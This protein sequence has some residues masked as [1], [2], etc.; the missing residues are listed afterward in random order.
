MVARE[1]RVA[2]GGA[3]PCPDARRASCSERSAPL[4]S[5]GGSAV[6]T[7][8]TLPPRAGSSGSVRRRG[9]FSLCALAATCDHGGI[10]G[11]PA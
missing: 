4:G 6:R 5:R 2:C 1:P 10:D 7:A 3:K 8:G 9:K 11:I